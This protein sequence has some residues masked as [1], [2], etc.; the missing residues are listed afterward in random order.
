MQ[1]TPPLVQRSRRRISWTFHNP[2][3]RFEERKSE[4]SHLVRI[5]A[6]VTTHANHAPKIQ[7]SLFPEDDGSTIGW[8]D[9]PVPVGYEQPWGQLRR[10]AQAAGL[11]PEMLVN[12]GPDGESGF[13]RLVVERGWKQRTAVLYAKVAGYGGL[14]VE[15]AATPEPTTH[16]ENL[17]LLTRLHNDASILEMRAVAWCSL[18]RG[19]PAPVD[20]WRH[21]RVDDVEVV[22]GDV[23]LGGRRIKGAGAAWNQWMKRRLSVSALAA[24]PY[25]LCSVRDGDWPDERQ[26][27]P[28][29]RRG[30]QAAFGRYVEGVAT[31]LTA[32]EHPEAEAV[33]ELTYDT[34]R[35]LVIASGVKPVERGSKRAV[36]SQKAIK[37]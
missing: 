18:A 8:D 27:N 23:M 7:P 34:F 33:R 28:L 17:Q 11:T 5:T 1:V 22:S 19:W 26:G 13:Q 14:H 31:Q 32:D 30:L 24:S 15:R 25:A 29:S 3:R 20:E 12:G 6:W 36:R 9:W 35:R 21:L 10:A 2:Y 4:L 37:V 16:L